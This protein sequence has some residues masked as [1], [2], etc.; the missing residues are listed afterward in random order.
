MLSTGLYYSAFPNDHPRL[1]N[2]VLLV[3]VLETIQ[4]VILTRGSLVRFA[5]GL[6]DN[7]LLANEVGNAWISFALMTGLSMFLQCHKI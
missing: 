3:F 1:K 4:T 6:S 2:L 7:L 5:A